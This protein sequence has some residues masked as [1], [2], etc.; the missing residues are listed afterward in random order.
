MTIRHLCRVFSVLVAI[1]AFSFGATVFA[2]MPVA[3]RFEDGVAAIQGTWYDLDGNEAFI[4]SG[5]SFNGR[6][7][8][9]ATNYMGSSTATTAEFRVEG[10]NGEG[11]STLDIVWMPNGRFIMVNGR[12][13][14]NT[15]EPTYFES[16]RGVYLGMKQEDMLALLGE[17]TR[18]IKN[19]RFVY[20]GMTVNTTG[21]MV[22]AIFMDGGGARLD[23]SG[24]GADDAP[25]DFMAAYGLDEPLGNKF[26]EIGDCGE[27]LKLV[28]LRPSP[29]MLVLSFADN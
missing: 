26:R 13:Y 23:G 24:L 6:K 5:D 20:P 18:N 28:N 9:G 3:D 21:G 2:S 25:E 27:K 19:W 7:I 15:K 10:E 22:N 12:S 14:R 8:L 16:V 17:P 4:V 29:N 11:F 1:A